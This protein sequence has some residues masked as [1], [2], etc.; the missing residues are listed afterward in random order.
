MLERIAAYISLRQSSEWGMRALQGSFSRLITR[1]TSDYEFRQKLLLSIILLHNFRTEE[2][3][4]NQIAEVFS[5][6]YQQ[7]ISLETY[8]KIAQYYPQI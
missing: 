3:G 4:I 6:H 8:D 1:L 5:Y 2:I 7:Y